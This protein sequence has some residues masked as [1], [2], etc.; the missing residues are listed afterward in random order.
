MNT[1]QNI[2]PELSTFNQILANE[3][4]YMNLYKSFKNDIQINK[5]YHLNNDSSKIDILD[6]KDFEIVKSYGQVYSF[7]A[8][9]YPKTSIFK[10]NRL[11]IGRFFHNSHFI[12]NKSNLETSQIQAFYQKNYWKRMF[13]WNIAF[14]TPAGFFFKYSKNSKFIKICMFLPAII[15][16]SFIPNFVSQIAIY[17]NS[18]FF[19]YLILN[20]PKSTEIKQQLKYLLESNDLEFILKSKV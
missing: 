4:E 14:L 12:N 15:S 2:I 1:K 3:L 7:K 20:D 19:A 6:Y 9:L 5:L 8:I 17:Q 16:F 18:Y 11:L 10:K 13:L